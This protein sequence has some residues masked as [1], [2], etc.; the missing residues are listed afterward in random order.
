MEIT[1]LIPFGICLAAAF[2]RSSTWL[3]AVILFALM[4]ALLVWQKAF[5]LELRQGVLRY[6]RLFGGITKV[7]LAEIERAGIEIGCFRFRDRFRPTVR[8]VI[9]TKKGS[10]VRPFDISVRVFEREGFEQLLD[11]LPLAK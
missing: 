6:R 9:T 5:L 1:L 11:V 4:V 2:K 3:P 8:L 10:S 7:A